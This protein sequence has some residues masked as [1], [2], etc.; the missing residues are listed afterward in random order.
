MIPYLPPE[1]WD[2]IFKYVWE[3]NIKDVHHELK[4]QCIM[5][6]REQIEWYR[7]GDPMVVGYY[8][9]LHESI[10]DIA[11]DD[12]FWKNRGWCSAKCDS[13]N[14]PHV[15]SICSKC[16]CDPVFCECEKESGIISKMYDLASCSLM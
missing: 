11:R 1:I 5:K 7:N 12:M 15:C 10:H 14:W 3:L 8:V 16:E 6:H 13:L 2:I 4:S 9:F